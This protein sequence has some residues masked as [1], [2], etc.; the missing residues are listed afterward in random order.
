[1]TV[2]YIPYILPPMTGTKQEKITYPTPTI[3]CR[4]DVVSHLRGKHRTYEKIKAAVIA[5]GR[6]S[7][8]DVESDKD[9]RLFTRL[10][11]N[12]PEIEMYTMAYPWT[13]IRLKAKEEKHEGT[14]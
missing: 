13:G 10:C 3:V 11:H 14:V 5:A 8:F 9:G 7:V 1:M 2:L 6:F 4:F 12:D